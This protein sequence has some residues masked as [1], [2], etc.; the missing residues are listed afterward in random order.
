M[1]MENWIYTL[2]FWEKVHVNTVHWHTDTTQVF[3]ILE[4][5]LVDH[6]LNS[7]LTLGSNPDIRQ[8]IEIKAKANGKTC[9][10]KTSRLAMF[11][12]RDPRP[13]QNGYSCD[14]NRRAMF[15]TTSLT[16]MEVQSIKDFNLKLFN[17]PFT[18]TLQTIF[19]WPPVNPDKLAS[20]LVGR[21]H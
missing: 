18:W 6:H 19:L 8:W 16:L 9:M 5:S 3:Q 2:S 1:V 4:S 7:T 11:K 20:Q 13:P 21:M 10:T 12:L 14:L 15:F 17:I